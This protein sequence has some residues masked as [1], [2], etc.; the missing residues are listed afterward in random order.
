MFKKIELH[1]TGPICDC[2]ND[3]NI[4]WTLLADR[5]GESE[6]LLFCQICNTSLTIP[7]KKLESYLIYG[8][9]H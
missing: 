3:G 6:L 9:K 2:N 5:N 7:H 1:L 4:A 8:E